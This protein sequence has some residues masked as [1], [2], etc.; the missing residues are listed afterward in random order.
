MPSLVFYLSRAQVSFSYEMLFNVQRF[1]GFLVW[2]P[3]KVLVTL[4]GFGIEAPVPWLLQ[5]SFQM[6]P[7]QDLVAGM[8]FL[9]RWLFIWFL[10][11]QFGVLGIYFVFFVLKLCNYLWIILQCLLYIHDLMLSMWFFYWLHVWT[12]HI[13]HTSMYII[14][15]QY[16]KGWDCS[17][18]F[19]SLLHELFNLIKRR[20]GTQS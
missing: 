7:G 2:C 8:A 9:R 10:V 18:K 15:R 16:G 12:G 13:V 17:N 14:G 1:Y 20:K 6:S 3:T 19:F 5:T 4:T 11:F